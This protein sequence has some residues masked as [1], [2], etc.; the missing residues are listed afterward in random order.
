MD[1]RIPKALHWVFK[2]GNLRKSVDFYRDVFGIRVLRHEEFASGC[3]ATCNGRYQGAWSKT[4]VG[5]GPENENF[6][7]ELTYNY[8]IES[9]EKGNDLRYIAVRANASAGPFQPFQKTKMVAAAQRLGYTVDETAEGTFVRGP[10]SQSYKLVESDR[11]EPVLFVSIN[12]SNLAR[13]KHFWCT[14]LGMREFSNVPGAL[15]TANS[16]VVGYHDKQVKLELV[17]TP[18]GEP[19][20][21][22]KAGGRIAFATGEQQPPEIY[23]HVQKTNEKVI[24]TPITLP[25]P[26]KADVQVVIL[27]DRDGYEICFVGADGFWDLS[28][29]RPGNDFIDWEARASKG[30]D[31]HPPPTQSWEGVD[32][33]QFEKAGSDA[34]FQAKVKEAG[35]GV[36]FVDFM[37]SWCKVCKEV[38]PAI[39]AFT[40]DPKF[41]AVK[42]VKV[43]VN[44]CEDTAVDY[45]AAKV[46]TFV[47]LKG[48]KKV[49]SFSGNDV[50]KIQALLSKHV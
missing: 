35:D 30:G 19:V 40:E 9:Y 18:N 2:V 3:E 17:A 14:V 26:G 42:F 44:D 50:A 6:A 29:L 36:V 15:G 28:K 33:K 5:Q 24:H 16:A 46:P 23:E 49:E 12:V 48:G 45:G 4:M 20:D 38:A 11:E 32:F 47:V 7:F 13:S 27:A 31:G 21:F 1:V 43:D 34:E 25:T 39:A 41:K 10:D 22:K 8:G 37:A